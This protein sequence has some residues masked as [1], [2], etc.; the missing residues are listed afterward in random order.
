MSFTIDKPCH[1]CGTIL[2]KTKAYPHSRYDY[3][4]SPNSEEH[5]SDRCRWE[6]TQNKLAVAVEE[7]DEAIYAR[8]GW[9][10][11]FAEESARS[12]ALEAEVERM[13]E[14]GVELVERFQTVLDNCAKY[15]DV[16]PGRERLREYLAVLSQSPTLEKK[17]GSHD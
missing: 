15:V 1:N 7:R 14:L 9:A 17:E 8:D 5:N 11:S 6:Q 3:I 10:T 12:A 4:D 16:A 13:R 2:Y